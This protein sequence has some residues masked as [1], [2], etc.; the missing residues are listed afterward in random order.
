MIPH[1]QVDEENEGLTCQVA[2]VRMNGLQQVHNGLE[3]VEHEG[4]LHPELL[5]EDAV[6]DVDAPT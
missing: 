4:D 2:A 1:S 5:T 3:D 6:L